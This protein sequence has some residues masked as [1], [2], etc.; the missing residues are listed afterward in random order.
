MTIVVFYIIALL[1]GCKNQDTAKLNLGNIDPHDLANLNLRWGDS[2]IRNLSLAISEDFTYEEQELIKDMA[3]KWDAALPTYKV[4]K[5]PTDEVE[6]K[7]YEKL[8]D[9]FLKDKEFGVYKAYDWFTNVSHRA[10][11][12]TQFFYVKKNDGTPFEYLEIIHADIIV[13][14]EYFSFSAD[15]DTRFHYDLPSVIL[16][17]LGHLLGLKHTGGSADSV[18]APS[19]SIFAAQR[20]LYPLDQAMIAINY[21]QE[22]LPDFTPQG[23]NEKIYRGVIELTDGG[24]CRI[25]RLR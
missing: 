16:H 7:L 19:M 6:N 8:E 1:F 17:E 25:S 12:I 24:H 10:L 15:P 18:M 22:Y 13:N 9:Y 23:K 5:F 2:R 3:L 14:F 11:A 20:E 21:G 4:F